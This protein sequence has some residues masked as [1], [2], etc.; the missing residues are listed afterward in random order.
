MQLCFTKYPELYARDVEDDDD[1]DF[2]D[3]EDVEPKKKGTEKAG[4][5]NDDDELDELVEEL[6]GE[7][8]EDREKQKTQQPRPSKGRGVKESKGP[9][10]GSP[11]VL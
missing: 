9:V 2:E 7:E 10:V 3:I 5:M 11:A 8:E 1:D 4:T 6:F